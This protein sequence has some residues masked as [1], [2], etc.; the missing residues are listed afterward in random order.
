MLNA[1][2]RN[3][4]SF[5]NLQEAEKRR[6]EEEAAKKQ[7]K[8]EQEKAAKQREDEN[9]ANYLAEI[10]EQMIFGPY[11]PR[12]LDPTTLKS[13]TANMDNH[14]QLSDVLHAE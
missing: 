9:R 4:P 2:A 8:E 13:P 7:E 11:R 14:A 6:L 12:Y 1:A 5:G 10:D 3:D